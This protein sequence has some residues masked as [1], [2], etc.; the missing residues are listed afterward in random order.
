M[1]VTKFQHSERSKDY[2]VYPFTDSNA[3]ITVSKRIPLG[4]TE[5]EAAEINWPALG[6]VSRLDA[7]YFTRGMAQAVSIAQK[8]DAGEKVEASEE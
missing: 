7:Q 6:N 5:W 2:R 4:G 8:I 1:K 3:F